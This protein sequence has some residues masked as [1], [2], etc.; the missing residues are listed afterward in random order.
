MRTRPSRKPIAARAPAPEGS[1][2]PAAPRGRCAGR[3]AAAVRTETVREFGKQAYLAAV[4]RMPRNTSRPATACR[5]VIGQ[6]IE[7]ALCRFAAV[8]VPRAAR[9]QSVALHV[10]LQLRR[11]ACRRRFAG[12]P[13][14]QR[15]SQRRWL[16]ESHDPPAGR[17]PPARRHAGAAMR[18]WRTNCW[19]IR[20]NSPN[21]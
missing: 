17:H 3:P 14:A 4:A 15:K 5:C 7:E 12:N 6:R 13:G 11:H 1:A 18:R 16:Q 10:L 9:A 21:T 8:A 20:R 2:Q 19:P